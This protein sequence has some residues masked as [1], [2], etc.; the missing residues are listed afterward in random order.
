MKSFRLVATGVFAVV[1]HCLAA[2][3]LQADEINP[4]KPFA[5]R[6]VLLQVSDSDPLKFQL[7]LD[8]ANNLIRHYGS[9]DAIDIQIVTFAGGVEMLFADRNAN[10]ERIRSLMAS[11][12]KFSVCLNTMDTIERKTGAR[13]ALIPG[14]NGVQTGV[15][16]MLE[17]IGRGYAHIHP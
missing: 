7:T 17:E 16:Y 14:V 12:V 8:I 2:F 6:H 4:E 1:L 15:A 3:P 5:E 11:E 13:P 9:T 10:S